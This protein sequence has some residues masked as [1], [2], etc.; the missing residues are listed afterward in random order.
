MAGKPGKLVKLGDKEAY[1]SPALEGVLG[2]ILQG[3]PYKLMAYYN[4]TSINTVSNQAVKVR[5]A[6]KV[7][8]NEELLVLKIQALEAEIKDY[9]EKMKIIEKLLPLLDPPIQVPL[10]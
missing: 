1:L 7:Q 2:Y 8:I 4:N 3:T 5:R 6:F 9:K 10:Q